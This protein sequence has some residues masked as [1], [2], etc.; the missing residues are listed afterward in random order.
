MNLSITDL[1]EMLI[2][3]NNSNLYRISDIQS[4]KHPTMFGLKIQSMKHKLEIILKLTKVAEKTKDNVDVLMDLIAPEANLIIYFS[5]FKEIKIDEITLR[6]QNIEYDDG[7]E[8]CIV[9]MSVHK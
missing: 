8:D 9:K 3:V 7:Q 5:M 4:I 1:L 6:V 2:D